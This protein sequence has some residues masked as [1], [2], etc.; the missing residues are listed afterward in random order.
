MVHGTFS[1]PVKWGEMM[2]TL[3]AD[4]VLR[5]RCQ[6]CLYLYSSSKPLVLSAAE[7]RDE[8]TAM[9]HQLDPEGRDTALLEPDS[10]S[11]ARIC[12]V[13]PL[14]TLERCPGNGANRQLAGECNP[15]GEVVGP[16]TQT[17]P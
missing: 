8:L 13:I 14:D 17:N 10:V 11:Q 4:S 7:F 16:F 2:N 1:S 15:C 6:I 9:I 5:Q 12:R 3:N